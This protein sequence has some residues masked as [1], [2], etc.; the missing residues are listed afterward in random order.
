MTDSFKMKSTQNNIYID[1]GD[2]FIDCTHTLPLVAAV[3]IEKRAGLVAQIIS[4][5]GKPA[6]IAALGGAD[7]PFQH[8]PH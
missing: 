2:G 6:L 7:H 5:N 3:S 8:R 4:A 1:C